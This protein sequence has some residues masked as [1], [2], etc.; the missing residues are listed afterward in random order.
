MAESVAVTAVLAVPAMPMGVPLMSSLTV[1]EAAAFGAG[2]HYLRRDSR[3]AV[4]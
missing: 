2:A 1:D 3:R 4:A